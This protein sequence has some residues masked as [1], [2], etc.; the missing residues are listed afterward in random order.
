MSEYTPSTYTYTEGGATAFSFSFE[1]FDTSHVKVKINGIDSINYEVWEDTSRV[2]VQDVLQDGDYIE[3]YRD[4][5]DDSLYT[6]FLTTQKTFPATS[7]N[8]VLQQLLYIASEGKHTDGYGYESHLIDGK[9]QEVVDYYNQVSTIKATVVT[10]EDSVTSTHLSVTSIQN[11]INNTYSQINTLANQ[12]SLDAGAAASSET[13]ALEYRNEAEVFAQNAASAASSTTSVASTAQGY[14]T[15]AQGIK[16]ATEAIQTAVEGIQTQVIADAEFVDTKKKEFDA[17]FLGNYSVAPTET[18]LG[19]P[20]SA[21][22]MY[23]DTVE[24]AYKGYGMNGEWFNLTTGGNNV[25]NEFVYTITTANFYVNGVDDNGQHLSVLEGQEVVTVD[26]IVMTRGVHYDVVDS[27]NILFKPEYQLQ[28]GYEVV[29]RVFAEVGEVGE[30]T[31]ESLG[32]D[33][34]DQILVDSSGAVDVASLSIGGVST[35]LLYGS[36]TVQDDLVVRISDAEDDITI[37][38]NNLTTLTG[39]VDTL[40]VV[41]TTANT[42]AGL[43]TSNSSSI[44]SLQAQVEAINVGAHTSTHLVNGTSTLSGLAPSGTHYLCRG[45]NGG[46]NLPELSNVTPNYRLTVDNVSDGGTIYI[47]TQGSD[48]M[49]N[50]GETPSATAIAVTNGASILRYTHQDGTLCWLVDTKASVGG[51]SSGT[52][53]NFNARISFTTSG[54]ANPLIFNQVQDNTGADFNSTTGIYTCPVDGIYLFTLQVTP[55]SGQGTNTALYRF[56]YNGSDSPNLDWMYAQYDGNSGTGST[57]TLTAQRYLTAGTQVHAGTI[58]S[59]SYRSSGCRFC[60]TL[61]KEV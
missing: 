9:V 31:L 11:D 53:S 59:S 46:L 2:K 55:T 16:D 26:G 44:A 41:Q 3:V 15:Q 32:I 50:N 47:N 28:Q 49:T 61:I 8:T 58:H 1:Y 4:T 56:Y 35:D 37:L 27:D 45:A 51:G 21:G 6:T 48:L 38:D 33:N 18:Y 19:I 54:A 43:A 39:R 17:V 29:V 57:A 12:A 24:N 30:V 34:H 40:Q 22:M 10:L 36:K 23:F 42:A 52:V 13:F 25:L 5:Q 14:V 60:G 20:L 7:I